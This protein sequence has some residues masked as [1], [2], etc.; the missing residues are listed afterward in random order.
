[1]LKLVRYFMLPLAVLWSLFDVAVDVVVVVGVVV[2]VVGRFFFPHGK[3]MVGL[4]AGDS[5]QGHKNVRN[6]RVRVR[7]SFVLL[8]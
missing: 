3:D 6:N 1:M 8:A 7:F 2:V 4:V 5:K